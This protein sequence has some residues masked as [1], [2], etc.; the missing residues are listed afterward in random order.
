MSFKGDGQGWDIDFLPAAGASEPHLEFYEPP[1]SVIGEPTGP[2]I[3]LNQWV[4]IAVVAQEEAG[5]YGNELRLYTNGVR[6]ALGYLDQ[7][8]DYT[9]THVCL[10]NNYRTNNNTVV[11]T[12]G[13]ASWMSCG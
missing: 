9:I 13:M 4:H 7:S 2:V 6:V 5:T 3:P 11:T 8:K 1:Y 12:I 10:G